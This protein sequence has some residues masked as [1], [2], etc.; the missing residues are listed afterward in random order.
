[1]TDEN[2]TTETIETVDV[3]VTEEMDNELGSMGK[4]DDA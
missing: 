1:M 4:G 2:K 3:D